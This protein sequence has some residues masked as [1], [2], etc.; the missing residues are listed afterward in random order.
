MDHSLSPPMFRSGL[1]ITLSEGTRCVNVWTSTR[2]GDGC[3]SGWSGA[4]GLSMA[5]NIIEEKE[6]KGE[7][8]VQA[9]VAIHDTSAANL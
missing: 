2:T 5:W 4:C 1:Y 3:R 7:K 9:A 6:E 8:K